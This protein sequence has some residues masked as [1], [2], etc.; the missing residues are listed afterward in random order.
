MMATKFK[1]SQS[2]D[3]LQAPSFAS[4]KTMFLAL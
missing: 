1:Q 2:D 3:E 4:K